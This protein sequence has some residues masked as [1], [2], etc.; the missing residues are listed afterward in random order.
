MR[1]E[2]GKVIESFFWACKANKQMICND[3]VPED[4]L[5][6]VRILHARPGN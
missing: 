6:S 2:C 5:A 4:V 3:V 1:A